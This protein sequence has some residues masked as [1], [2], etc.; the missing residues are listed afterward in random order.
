MDEKQV[1][2]AELA[3]I[4]AS[5]DLSELAGVKD[6]VDELTDALGL[7]KVSTEELA[8]VLGITDRR[9]SQLWKA[10]QI[11]EPA[12][13]GNKHYFDLLQSVQGYIEFLRSR[14]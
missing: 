6:P 3:E 8:L 14:T 5:L 13:D 10:G 7:R 9:I 1:T 12:R 4:F 2:E 11:P